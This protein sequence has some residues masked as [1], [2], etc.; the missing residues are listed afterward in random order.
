VMSW[1][2]SI[3]VRDYN[4]LS[5]KTRLIQ[6]M[7]PLRRRSEFCMDRIEILDCT[8]SVIPRY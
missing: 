5:A 6:G 1:S 2:K 3:V 7:H 4:G 8:F